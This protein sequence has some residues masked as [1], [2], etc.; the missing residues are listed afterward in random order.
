MFRFVLVSF[1]TVQKTMLCM[2]LMAR[3]R[4][5]TK[6]CTDSGQKRNER[7]QSTFLD[8]IVMFRFVLVSF[9]TVQKIMLCMHLM[10]PFGPKM[11]RCTDSG[12]KR[13]E[14]TQS[15]FLDPIVMFR[16]V[17]VSFLTVQKTMLCMH[18]M[19]RLGP[20][21]KR[22]T[23]SGQKR[24]ER[25]QSTFLDPV[26]MF[27]F[28]LVSFVTVQKTM[29]CMHLMARFGPKTER[30]TDSGLKRNERTQSTFLDPIVMFMFVLVSFVTVQITM[31]CMDLMPRFGP[32]TK[33][34]TDSCQKRK[35][36]FLDPIVMF[37]FVLVSFVTVQKTMLCM[38]LMPP[39][40]PETK[41]C[42]D[43]GQKRNERTQSTF[44]D[45]IVMF[46]FVLVSFVTVQKNNALYAFNGPICVRNETN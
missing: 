19:P 27:R 38:H 1:V 46:R 5:E 33:R 12:Q 4:P 36:T 6:R 24:N 17:L 32:E 35:N 26:V 10:P 40:G 3:F 28:V 25:A 42:T 18:L 20:E 11:K 37:R 23:D 21:T 13:N 30:C 14:R 31:L 43:S 29:L 34:C 7:T 16:F 15:T 41:R 9:V 44:L 8:P 39:F 45:P 2:L 22:C